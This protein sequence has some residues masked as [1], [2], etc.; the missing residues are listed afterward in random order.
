VSATVWL[1]ADTLD[2]PLG[3]GHLWAYLNWALGLRAA[4]CEVV[5]LEPVD[6]SW[7]AEGVRTRLTALRERLAP[8][9][10]AGAIALC[11]K[12]SAPV[13]PPG[14]DGCVDVSAARDAD[15]LLNLAGH[16]F[17]PLLDRFPRTAV[18]DLDPGLLQMWTQAE[19]VPLPRYDVHFTVG[20]GM[21]GVETHS[22][23]GFVSWE[24]T[25]P[26]VAVDWWP[27]SAAS[28]SAPFTTVSTWSS[29]DWYTDGQS[30]HRNQKRDGFL[31]Y[32]D[33]PRRTEQPLELALCLAD[34]ED[35]DRG[36]LEAHGWRVVH[37]EDVA[38][39]PAAYQRYIQGSR[40]EFSCAKPSSVRFEKGWVSDRTLCYL[41][42][43]KPVVIEH[44]GRSEVLVDGEGVF[45][46]RS[47]DE[48]ARGLEAVAEDYESQCG[49]ARQLAEDVF[50]AG[51]IVPR[52]LERCLA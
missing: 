21:G 25:P 19:L 12:D 15:L 27:V 1:G 3:G 16:A 41:A 10:L 18:V 6:A 7:D 40:G 14:A 31:P 52:V 47:L 20:E 38:P 45:R 44:T 8:Y 9:G 23:G 34:D 33:L 42:S 48:A 2:F 35:D 29:W 11:P 51:R 26:C 46:F 13:V 22:R 43:G 17:E 36:A 32:L 30:W 28:P 5:W 24:Y 37:A 49:L 50:D 39:T 4:G